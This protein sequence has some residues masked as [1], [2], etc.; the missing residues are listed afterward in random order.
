MLVLSLCDFSGAWS[1]PYADAGHRVVR[2]DMQHPPGEQQTGEN[3]WTIGG[4]V[5]KLD[6]PWTPG[7]VLAA[8]PCTCF[9][10]PAARWWGRQ[11]ADG[12]TA[13]DMATFRAC[14]RIC[15]TA[16]CYWALENPPG[17]QMKLMPEIGKPAWQFQPWEFGDPWHKQTYIWGTA[18]RP[19]ATKI[20][21][22]PPTIRAP[23][24][25]TQ[26]F[27]AR[28]SSSWANERAKTPAGFAKAF[29]EANNIC[30]PLQALR[31]GG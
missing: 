4:D 19:M 18:I 28:M 14:L 26:G 24:G 5:S 30:E 13:R 15:R 8:P 21:K 29:Y 27:I 20:V 2:V 23:S 12:S 6:F 7:V 11:D 22:P 9:C 31:L 25:S 3:T 10:R 1:Q 16:S 17:R